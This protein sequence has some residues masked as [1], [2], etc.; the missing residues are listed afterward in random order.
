MQTIKY[1]KNNSDRPTPHLHQLVSAELL[2]L[3]QRHEA[4]VSRGQRL[5][6][7][8]AA[9]LGKVVCADGHQGALAAQILMQLVLQESGSDRE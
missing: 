3:L 4:D 7:E 2:R 1:D 9:A 6:R 5:I 8:G